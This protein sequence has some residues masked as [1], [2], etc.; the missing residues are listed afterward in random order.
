LAIVEM[1]VE[2]PPFIA[3]AFH[4]DALTVLRLGDFNRSD[5]K[6]FVVGWTIR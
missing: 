6:S 4:A 3:S 2:V 1:G 5:A